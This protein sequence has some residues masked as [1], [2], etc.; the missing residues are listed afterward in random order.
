L[1]LSL[2]LLPH[3]PSSSSSTQKSYLAILVAS[4]LFDFQCLRF[5]HMT[6]LVGSSPSLNPR[7]PSYFPHLRMQNFLGRPNNP[8]P[9]IMFLV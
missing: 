8:I 9:R 3:G 4:L 1:S 5:V 7:P 2:P 6:T